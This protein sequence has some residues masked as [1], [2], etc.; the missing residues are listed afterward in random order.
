MIMD[1]SDKDVIPQA[2]FRHRIAPEM[3]GLFSNVSM[4]LEDIEEFPDFAEHELA[5]DYNVRKA[6]NNMQTALKSLRNIHKEF[7]E[8]LDNK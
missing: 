1:Y 3:S 6:L 2:L 8:F 7:I 4:M 5:P